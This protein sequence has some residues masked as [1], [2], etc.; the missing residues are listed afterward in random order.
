MF[1]FLEHSDPS[2]VT[3]YTLS[4]KASTERKKLRADNDEKDK[5]IAE[6]EAQLKAVQMS[7]NFNPGASSSSKSST[8]QT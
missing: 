7:T 5:K 3:E 4:T 8:S 2:A 6:L 1:R